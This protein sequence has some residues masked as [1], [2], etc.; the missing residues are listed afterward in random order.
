[1]SV[2]GK[3]VGYNSRTER[4]ELQSSDDVRTYAGKVAADAKLEVANPAIGQFYQADKDARGDAIVVGRRADPLAPSAPI[5]P[6]RKRCLSP[7][8]GVGIRRP[9]GCSWAKPGVCTLAASGA[10]PLR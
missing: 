3:L 4:Y 8:P 7:P 2:T 6:R 1:M 5:L 10:M 9:G